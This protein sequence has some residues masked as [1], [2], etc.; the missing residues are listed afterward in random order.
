MDTA[1]QNTVRKRSRSATMTDPAILIPAIGGAFR[2]L[3]PRHMI[4]SPVM[5]V[6]EIVATLTTIL[7]VRDLVMGNWRIGL[8]VPDQSVAL[9]HGRLRQFRRSRRRG[10]GK[11]QADSLR[12][13]RTDT[14]AKLMDASRNSWRH[15]RRDRAEARRR[16][17]RRG[18]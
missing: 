9:V 4:K 3:D 5:F 12:Q 17:P 14:L 8:L 18:G 7:F 11:A 15:C 10:R 6:V 16:G 1:I 13:T 2:K